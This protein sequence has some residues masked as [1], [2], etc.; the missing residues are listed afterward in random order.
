LVG[1]LQQDLVQG[2]AIR[3]GLEHPQTEPGMT[4]P[5]FNVSVDT[6]A[7]G[8]SRFLPAIAESVEN[9]K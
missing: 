7:M 5:L 8:R 9:N 3:R 4:T 1:G 6:S 2:H